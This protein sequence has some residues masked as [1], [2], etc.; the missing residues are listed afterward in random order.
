MAACGLAAT[1]FVSAMSLTHPNDWGHGW[2]ARSRRSTPAVD[3][4]TIR[5]FFSR[6]SPGGYRTPR[7]G[8]GTQMAR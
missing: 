3:L 6:F 8:F 7:P 4:E 5:L 1:S 2:D